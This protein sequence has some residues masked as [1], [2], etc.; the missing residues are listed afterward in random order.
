MILRILNKDV[1]LRNFLFVLGEGILIYIAVMTAAFLRIGS[2]NKS[3]LSPEII[4]KALLIVVICQVSL[5]FNEL[6]NLEVTGTYL[7]LGLRLTKA[8][9]IASI[10]LAII[11]YCIPSLLV[12]RGIFFISLAFLILLVVS[13]RYAYNWILKKKILQLKT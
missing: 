8:I 11:Y 13:W 3:F 7:E 12:G 9:G 2:I 1:P 6:Y 4:S 5:Y 10:T